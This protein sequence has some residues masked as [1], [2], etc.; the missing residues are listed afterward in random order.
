MADVAQAPEPTRSGAPRWLRFAYAVLIAWVGYRYARGL[1]PPALGQDDLWVGVL[2]KYAT[3]GDLLV[4]KAPVPMGFIAAQQLISSWLSD[5]EVALQIVPFVCGLLLIPLTGWAGSRLSGR[6]EVG[7]LAAVLVALHP[8]S[9]A[10]AVR[11]K[12]FTWDAATTLVLLAVGLRHLDPDEAPKPLALAITAMIALLFSF[13]AIF[14]GFMLCHVRAVMSWGDRRAFGRAAAGALA[15]DL[16]AL[17]FYLYRL[18]PQ[19]A[20]WIVRFWQRRGA[21]PAASPSLAGGVDVDW[22]SRA[23]G[24]AYTR[25]LVPEWRALGVAAPIGLA[26]LFASR[27][28]RWAGLALLGFVV[29]L[30]VAGLLRL[31]PFGGGR[32]DYF[33]QPVLAVLCAGG[34]GSVAGWIAEA[35]GRGREDPARAARIRLVLPLLLV[36]ALLARGPWK[37]GRYGNGTMTTELKDLV[38]TLDARTTPDD[39][40]WMSRPT[41]W[42]IAYYTKTPLRLNFTSP[43]GKLF[44]YEMTGPRSEV[45]T[46][47]ARQ[48]ESPDAPDEIVLAAFLEGPERLG[49]FSQILGR[50][51]YEVEWYELA[52]RDGSIVAKFVRKPTPPQP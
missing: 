37:L 42:N 22:L 11:V 21:F 39:V 4:Y 12:Q 13:N 51:G 46:N 36:A 30:P 28:T 23:I 19:S 20:E 35:V 3:P 41:R 17:A 44:D 25:W 26:T 10:Y 32:T 38:A 27:R 5:P 14:L 2:V 40:V 48:L 9:G 50:S 34:L 33:F 31:Y 29:V 16:F 45:I 1:S 8:E 6:W 18:E 47:V 24:R 49:R 43:T 7:L 15:F 52:R